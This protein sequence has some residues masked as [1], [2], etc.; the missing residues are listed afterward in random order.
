M[1]LLGILDSR[2]KTE[3]AQSAQMLGKLTQVPMLPTVIV[4]EEGAFTHSLLVCPKIWTGKSGQAM[5]W[6][7][8]G[9]VLTS[10]FSIGGN[11]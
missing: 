5:T 11:T 4:C 6:R 1:Y 8:V 7:P 9:A 10:T 3:F 2:L